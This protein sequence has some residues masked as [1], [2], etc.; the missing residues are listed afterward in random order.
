MRVSRW[1][2]LGECLRWKRCCGFGYRSLLAR[3]TRTGTLKLN[4][5]Y[6]LNG[7]VAVSGL[8]DEGKILSGV[9]DR[10]DLMF[11]EAMGSRNLEF[12]SAG[13]GLLVPSSTDAWGPS[14][15]FGTSV[16]T[17]LAA[18]EIALGLEEYPEASANQVLQAVVRTA[19]IARMHEPRRGGAK[20]GYGLANPMAILARDPTQ[21]PDESPLFGA[22]S[23]DP[24]CSEP[25]EPD[26][27][28]MDGCVWA[29]SPTFKEIWPEASTQRWSRENRVKRTDL[30]GE[31]GR[32]WQTCSSSLALRQLR[33]S[34]RSRGRGGA[35]GGDVATLCDESS[36][37]A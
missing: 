33:S 13:T 18:G 25:G 3:Q 27:T 2:F 8:D 17:P 23:D 29:L 26:A 6:T 19:G 20:Q 5:P 9:G 22:S 31:H 7:A 1:T 12:L 28:S 24:R 30:N 14:L 11:G 10:L 4:Y 15:R 34:C 36:L 21:Y 37:P 16:A 32:R 35:T